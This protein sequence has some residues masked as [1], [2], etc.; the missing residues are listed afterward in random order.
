MIKNES[1]YRKRKANLEEFH[2]LLDE[3][4]RETDNKNSIR[5][6]SN[7]ESLVSMIEEISEELRQYDAYK[8]GDDKEIRCNHFGEISNM[9]IAA[10]IAQNM[11]QQELAEKAGLHTQQIQKY[12]ANDYLEVKFNTLTQ[13]ASALGIYHKFKGIVNLSNDETEQV[14]FKEPTGTNSKQ[15]KMQIV[16]MKEEKT[17]LKIAG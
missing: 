7:K 15:V 17:I 8:S 9:L 13:I 2:R 6:I 3:L 12:E 5:Y 16:R 11:T 10:R 4:E 1:H 14:G